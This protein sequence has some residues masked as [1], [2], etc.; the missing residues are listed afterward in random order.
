MGAGGLR[1]RHTA[2]TSR[3]TTRQGLD[4]D[5]RVPVDPQATERRGPEQELC[6]HLVVDF[7]NCCW[8]RYP[9]SWDVTFCA[10]LLRSVYVLTEWTM[11]SAR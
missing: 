6:C 2:E 3:G 8:I 4:A 7:W 9:V 11:G 1:V 5:L 10:A